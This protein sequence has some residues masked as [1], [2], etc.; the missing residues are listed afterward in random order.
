MPELEFE[1]WCGC[2]N[3]LCGVTEVRGRSVTVGPCDS[4][5]ESARQEGHDDG[6][7]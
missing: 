4:C 3:G 7:R 5:I 1:V 6:S 2:G